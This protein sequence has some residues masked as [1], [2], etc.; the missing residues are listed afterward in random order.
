MHVSVDQLGS[1]FAASFDATF[2]VAAD[3]RILFANASSD[4]V[5]GYPPS[6]LIGRHVET[7]IPERFRERHATLRSRYFERPLGRLVGSGMS[8]FGLHKR[9]HEFPID[10]GL[11]PITLGGAWHTVCA[12]RD[13]SERSKLEV[14]THRAREFESSARRLETELKT[15]LAQFEQFIE[16]TPAAV[17][18]FDRDMHYL[19]SSERW[20][21]DYGLGELELR[22]RQHYEVFPEIPE[23]WKEAHRRGLQGER[24]RA[25]EDSF[26]RLDGSVE[27]LRWEILPW[28][29]A[30]GEVGGIAILTEVITD[31]RQALERLSDRELYFSTLFNDSAV[32]VAL[33]E[34]P[35]GVY[36]DVNRE[37]SDLFG[38]SLE[39]VRGKTSIELGINTSAVRAE[40]I[41]KVLDR[42]SL[43]SEEVTLRSKS[44][45]KIEV[46][47]S[48]RL[49]QIGGRDRFVLT[50][51]DR[52][53]R[54]HLEREL[55][56]AVAQEQVRIGEELHD[57]L[58]QLLAGAAFLISAV[59]QQARKEKLTIAS[60]LARI[61]ELIEESIGTTRSIAQGLSPLVDARGS[62]LGA[63]RRQ[64]GMLSGE[65]LTID[66][67]GSEATERELPAESRAQLYRIAHE[68]IQYAM[69][70]AAASRIE[71]E[72]TRLDDA[73]QLTIADDGRGVS[74]GAAEA[75]RGLSLM[76]HRAEAL[77]GRATVS[78]RPG[79][80]TLVRCVVPRPQ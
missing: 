45:A 62:L 16:H 70:H 69:K 46:V 63:L 20:R 13:A 57:G 40:G 3:G 32:P 7:L 15:T 67:S 43:R 75:M 12:V 42:G 65:E 14:L 24:I 71:V 50:Y 53:E 79:G 48:V 5:F 78:P 66:I 80:G 41:K 56:H 37:W 52:T 51:V 68:A 26:V 76:R 58:S 55:G 21:A 2:V 72:L 6:E 77:G 60:E 49:V 59:L 33:Q 1:V 34:A 18:I 28:C 47:V 19:A 38:Y 64:A 74:D 10:V 9:G 35:S 39:E 44:G 29:D 73:C 8:L 25:E 31:E 11:S 27:W 30:G 17:A 23:R 61:R 22:G 54:R 36:I 4:P